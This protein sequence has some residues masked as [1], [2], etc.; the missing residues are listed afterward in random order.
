[1]LAVSLHTNWCSS[2]PLTTSPLRASSKACT[3]CHLQCTGSVSRALH[4]Y[5]T[6]DRVLRL[7]EASEHHALKLELKKATHS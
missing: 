2:T 4:D 1:M 6:N 3:W 7:P 5:M